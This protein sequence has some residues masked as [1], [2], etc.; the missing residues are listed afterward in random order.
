MPGGSA[1]FDNCQQCVKGTTGREPCDVCYDI[2]NEI[3][4]VMSQYTNNDLALRSATTDSPC[5]STSGQIYRNGQIVNW[6]DVSV[7]T[8]TSFGLKEAVAKS[9]YTDYQAKSYLNNII[10]NAE[11]VSNYGLDSKWTGLLGVVAASLKKGFPA[12]VACAK[13][14]V[15]VNLSNMSDLYKNVQS[16]YTTDPNL[17]TGMYVIRT[18]STI[19]QGDAVL[20]TC[21]E[22][23]YYTNGCP[24]SKITY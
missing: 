3:D 16:K 10:S 5:V 23:F 22:E 24:I 17:Q 14:M 15:D 19:S 9:Y 6:T 12:V 18:I 13:G 4:A 11:K 1:Y 7:G 2:Q 8:S 20:T 21:T